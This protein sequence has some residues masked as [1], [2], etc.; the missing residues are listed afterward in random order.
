MKSI[1]YKS[2]YLK[3]IFSKTNFT[4]Q[5]SQNVTDMKVLSLLVKSNFICQT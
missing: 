5:L 2:F 1:K 4:K 3:I